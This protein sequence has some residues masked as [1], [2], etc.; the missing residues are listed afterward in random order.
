MIPFHQG[1]STLALLIFETGSFLVARGCPVHCRV[2][3]GTPG[4]Y[5][6]DTVTPTSIATI[7]D[8]CCQMFPGD[9]LI[10]G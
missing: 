6:P 1:F 3:S 4:L 5:P 9:Q 2:F 10:P 7:K 8:A